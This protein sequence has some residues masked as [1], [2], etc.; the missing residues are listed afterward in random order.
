M[1]WRALIVEPPRQMGV[2]RRLTI[3]EGELVVRVPWKLPWVESQARYG[4]GVRLAKV[5]VDESGRETKYWAVLTKGERDGD[6]GLSQRADR[7]SGETAAEVG[8][9]R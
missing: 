8:R 7:S 5:E 1:K 4:C 2:E 6:L 3:D 9:D